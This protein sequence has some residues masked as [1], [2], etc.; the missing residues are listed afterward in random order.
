[1]SEPRGFGN[2][3]L[4]Q[5]ADSIWTATAPIRFAGV[6][7]PHVMTVVRLSDGGVLLHS[8]CRLS[9]DLGAALA[10]LGSVTGVIAPNW[11]H[12]LY[13]DDYRRSY[14][15]A[16]FW[17]PSFLKRQHKTLIDR[18]LDGDARPRWFAEIPHITV[19][20]LLTFDES[21]F[22]HV[23][24]RT[25]VV[26]DLLT[27]ARVTDD[28]PLFT[29]FGYRLFGLDGGLKAFP[30]LVWFGQIHRTAIRVAVR[31]MFEWNPERLIVGHGTPI[32]EGA[33]EQLRAA[34]RWIEAA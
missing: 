32:R 9:S 17:G 10:R 21:I 19:P 30:L 14:P 15:S 34:F 18:V 27:N 28:A 16:T 29:K 24:T 5:F 26:A 12:D 3:K 7:Q 33:A 2:G 13:L 4:V 8:P 20:G 6:W 23:P 1:M 31:Q 11:F 22:Y 25:L